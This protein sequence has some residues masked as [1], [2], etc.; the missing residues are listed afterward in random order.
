MNGCLKKPSFDTD[1][2]ACIN[3]YL[4]Q[5]SHKYIY[6]H[7]YIYIYIYTY[8]YIII[9]LYMKNKNIYH[10]Y[11]PASVEYLLKCCQ[12]CIYKYIYLEPSC[13]AANLKLDGNI[14]FSSQKRFHMKGGPLEIEYFGE[15]HF[16]EKPNWGNHSSKKSFSSSLWVPGIYH[17]NL[18]V[19]IRCKSLCFLVPICE[20][21]HTTRPQMVK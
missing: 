6:M 13:H 18:E 4:R 10:M 8:I 16:A 19:R 21:T 12:I 9:F 14:F 2:R 15:N 3:V 1:M 5:K 7:I 11:T 20:K 17:L